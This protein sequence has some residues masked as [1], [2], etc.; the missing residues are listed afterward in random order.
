MKKKDSNRYSKEEGSYISMHIDVVRVR[1]RVCI[2]GI[3]LVYWFYIVI[4]TFV[5]TLH[6]VRYKTISVMN[7][8]KVVEV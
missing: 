3:Y 2:L 1:Y 7:S 5:Y 8:L 4:R 6:I